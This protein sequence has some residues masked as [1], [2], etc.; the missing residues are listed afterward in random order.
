[1]RFTLFLSAVSLGLPVFALNFVD[2]TKPDAVT[3]DGVPDDG[4]V[5]VAADGN[6]SVRGTRPVSWVRL[7]WK[8]DL[9][10]G[11][12]VLGGEWE[13]T[14]GDSAWHELGVARDPQ[15]RGGAMPW[16]FLASDG[17]RTDGYGVMTQPN[18]FASWH[19]A[20]NRIEL[21]LD[22][23]AG[24][25]PVKLA[26][27]TLVACRLVSRRGAA[28]ESAFAA[29]REFCR[30]MC[31]N[32]RLPKGPVYGYNDWY[33]AYG[34]NTATNFL[35]DAA[36]VCSLVKGEKVRPYIVVDDGWQANSSTLDPVAP[37]TR[38][39]GV[40]ERWGLPMDEVARRVK[41]MD[42]RPGLW[43]RP[44]L[45]DAG[46]RKGVPMDPTDPDLPDRIREEMRRF[47]DW[48]YELV[49]TDFITFEWCGVWG[50]SYGDSPVV[51]DLPAWRDESRTTVETVKGLYR[52]IREGAGDRAVVIGC[53]ALDHLAAGLFELQRTGDDTSGR[54]WERTRKMGPNTLGMR[55]IHDRTF[56]VA[57]G[58]CFG[59]VNADSVPA[60]LNLR[61]LDLIARSGTALFVSWKRQ[62]TTPEYAAALENALRRAAKEQP[63][64]EPLDWLET[65]RPTRW[66]FG[67]E[68]VLYTWN[69]DFA[70]VK[71]PEW[72]RKRIDEALAR[73]R[74]WKGDDETVTIT[75][76][77]DI[78]SWTGDFPLQDV[79]WW[80]HK[81]HAMLGLRVAAAFGSE[82][83][84]DLGDTGLDC[85]K[86]WTVPGDRDWAEFRMRAQDELYREI[87]RP[88]MFLS[89]NH[90]RG[91][92][93][94]P[95]ANEAFGR[96]FNIRPGNGAFVTS[97]CGTWGFYDIPGKAV[98]VI[99][100]NTDQL[101]GHGIGTDQL[102][103]LKSA[104]DGSGDRRVLV[105]SHVCLDLEVGR[106]M[107]YPE[108]PKERRGFPETRKLLEKFASNHPGRLLAAFAGDSHYEQDQVRNGVRYM[109]TQSY[110]FCGKAD[111][112]PG[113]KLVGFD[114]SKDCLFDVIAIKPATGE[115]KRIRVGAGAEK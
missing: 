25:H 73:F 27:R 47:V 104:L 1:M 31:P 14:Y 93:R 75:T 65:P 67:D 39:K 87:G 21:V 111:L 29:G 33:C 46:A 84:A 53:N 32:P 43:Y 76:V 10:V 100:L 109:I 56:Y 8:A 113:A 88:A 5:S 59:L 42:G 82:L 61:W 70:A 20:T 36:F 40:N 19:A 96:R 12:K 51:K 86:T 11:T 4:L 68:T 16:Y 112:T 79:W 23:R 98:R 94:A 3:V 106:W 63:T 99:Y 28:G 26:G 17:T 9:P 15:P 55:A 57:D 50:F 97:A 95:L 115:L 80:D 60:R 30:V 34:K 35:A 90:D 49:K 89:G 110:G 78:H 101:S 71:T 58:D 7:S 69:P 38:W 83:F 114:R 66:R 52:A 77:S 48:G 62:L 91:T 108:P 107:R 22:C 54:E 6:V 44:F 72:A 64:G 103:F 13:R 18:A 74:E 45:P 24:S 37:G 92:S 81:M 85:H 41:E 105:L 102:E 2:L